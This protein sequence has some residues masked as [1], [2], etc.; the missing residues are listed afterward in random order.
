MDDGIFHLSQIPS[1][2]LSL[3]KFVSQMAGIIM[4][5]NGIL[6]LLKHLNPHKAAGPG[7]DLAS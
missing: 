5:L 4:C 7:Q 2:S 1:E 6:K 3:L